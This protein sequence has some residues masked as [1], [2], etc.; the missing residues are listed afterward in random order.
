MVKSIYASFIRVHDQVFGYSTQS[1]AQ[2]VNLRSVHQVSQVPIERVVS[3]LEATGDI[4]KSERSVMFEQ[5][6]RLN[7][8]IYDRL[9]LP[10]DFSFD[11]PA[12]I[13]QPDTTTV[14][15]EG[16]NAKVCTAGELVLQKVPVIS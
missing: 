12:I 1:P 5:T 9:M 15:Y 2:I 14:L 16:W 7:V 8:P 3:S 10:A 4:I 6:L 13:E 11:G